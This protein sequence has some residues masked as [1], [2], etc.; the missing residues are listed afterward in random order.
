MKL[1]LR[2]KFTPW[3]GLPKKFTAGED[4]V[5]IKLV[6]GYVGGEK[7]YRTLGGWDEKG[8]I[9][10]VMMTREQARLTLFHELFHEA[11]EQA[12]VKSEKVEP[13]IDAVDDQLFRIIDSNPKLRR[14]LFP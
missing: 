13:F 14:F 9:L 10:S 7:K 4:R 2:K 6:T 3:K 11:L 8:I 5:A 12:G 1:P